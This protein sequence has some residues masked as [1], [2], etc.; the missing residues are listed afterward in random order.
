MAGRGQ[1]TGLTS[2][3]SD[4]VEDM[5]FSRSARARGSQGTGAAY[6]VRGSLGGW[7]SE[8]IVGGEGGVCLW[9]REGP[10]P[11]SRGLQPGG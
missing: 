7:G 9:R 8:E 11:P 3:A 10:R 1:D 6:R 5:T 4:P 2:P